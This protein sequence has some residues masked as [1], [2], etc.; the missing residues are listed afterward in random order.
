MEKEKRKNNSP[1]PNIFGLIFSLLGTVIG[2]IFSL[3]GWI[4]KQIAKVI[5]LILKQIKAIAVFFF[6]HG[7]QVI[8]WLVSQPYH[9]LRYI[10][11]GRIPE[12]DTARQEEI[13][14]RIK[15]QYRR[16]RLFALNSFLYAGGLI[17]SAFAVGTNYYYATQSID[18]WAW[19]NFYNSAG[20]ALFFMGIWTLIL[21]FHYV[22]NRM[23]DAE[24][25]AM[26][27]ALAEE[28]ARSDTREEVTVI[29]PHAY[30]R[31]ADAENDPYYDEYYDEKPKKNGARM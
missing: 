10:I 31:L 20:S 11:S 19:Q 16:K 3:I 9:L 22:F 5:N 25:S 29:D 26:G 14:W 15:R 30:Y 27:E 6:K 8:K 4:A 12:F 2:G 17:I 13:F 18:S 7:W 23:G 21:G 28:Y 1:H 24:D